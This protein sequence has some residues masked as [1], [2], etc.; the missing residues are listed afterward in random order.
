MFQLSNLTAL[1]KK[2]KRIGRGGSRG[3]TSG[4]GNK[5][6]KAR[7]GG[8]GKVRTAF[9]G[10]QMPLVRRLPKRGFNNK[11]FQ[12]K[13]AVVNLAA[14]ESGFEA[15]QEVTAE[16][17]KQ[18]GILKGAEAARVKVLGNGTLTKKLVVRVHAASESAVKMIEQCG[19]K[20]ELVKEI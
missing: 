15:G 9:E 7:T 1:V 11:N 18:R 20:V 4:K 12:T 5:G 14:L 8:K 3:G 13:F 6:Q 10:G 2:R 16:L 19:G 17:L